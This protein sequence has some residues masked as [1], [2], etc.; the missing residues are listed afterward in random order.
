M[1]RGEGGKMG[2]DKLEALL[3]PHNHVPHA[4]TRRLWLPLP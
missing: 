2:S 1:V 3:S 4:L